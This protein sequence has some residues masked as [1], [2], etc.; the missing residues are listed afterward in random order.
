MCKTAR[1]PG[2]FYR[3]CR[4]TGN[5]GHDLCG[6]RSRRSRWNGRS[7]DG[8]ALPELR[9]RVWK[10][11]GKRVRRIMRE[12]NL[13]CLRRRKYVVTTDSNHDLPVYPNLAEEMTLT[14]INQLWWPISPTS[15]WKGRFYPSVSMSSDRPIP[16]GLVAT[17]ARCASTGMPRLNC[18]RFRPPAIIIEWQPVS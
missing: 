13:L 6:T 14:G 3:H 9:D 12:D 16:D 5:P 4:R 18:W 7:T 1:K 10:V 8:G 11:N 2:G 15:G 17:R